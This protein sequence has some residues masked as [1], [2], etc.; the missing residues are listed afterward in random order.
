MK[1]PPNPR[2]L[3]DQAVLVLGLGSFGGGAGTARALHRLGAKVAVSDLRPRVEL[4][5]A[6]AILAECEG[7]EW[8]LGGHPE[9]IFCGQLVV[10][11]PAVPREAEVLKIAQAANCQLVSEIDL[12]L[13]ARSDLRYLAITGTHG[14][15]TCASLAAHLLEN[16]G[17][18][19]L[20]AGNLGGSLL[21]QILDAPADTRVV[22]ELS[23]FQTEAI[24]APIGW[25]EVS[26]LTCLGSD[27]LDRH[28]NLDNYWRAKKRLLIAQKADSLCLV[29][30][31]GK[32]IEEWTAAC[33][34]EIQRLDPNSDWAKGL[35]ENAP[36]TE[37]Y[38]LPSL[39]AAVA[40]AIRLGCPQSSIS[41]SLR[42]W[43]GLPH[44]MQSMS[45]SHPNLCIIDNA[46]A[47]HPDPTTAALGELSGRVILCAGGYDK[48]LDLT[49]LATAASKCHQVHLSGP[50]GTRL[51]EHQMMQNTSFY[52]HDNCRSAFNDAL[53]AA[54]QSA[55]Q[56]A[57]TLLYS[58]SFSSF[59]EFRNFRDRAM[60]FH[61]IVAKSSELFLKEDI[62]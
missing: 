9:N 4:S 56:E 54:V 24:Q 47:T 13:A 61:E 59:D 18:P 42:S 3:Q 19:V 43:P 38:R 46:V 28:Q 32:G 50:G 6:S 40:G 58:P 39:L 37:S 15:S 57:T 45:N 34:G 53:L 52:L 8:Y 5:E 49:K 62:S 1:T 33:R 30:I 17:I 22:L 60:M 11:N 36:F 26:V 12:A 2:D 21:E 10:V 41:N 14:K 20:L 44:R 16:A 48:K 7:I 55:E 29:P 27:H 23:S 25:P 31:S 35:L 51:A